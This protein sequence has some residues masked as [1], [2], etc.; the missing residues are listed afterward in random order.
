GTRFGNSSRCTRPSTR[1]WHIEWSP[2]FCDART[3]DG[4]RLVGRVCDR[5]GAW[6]LEM[7]LD[8]M[9]SSGGGGLDLGWSSVDL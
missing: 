5:V 4:T 6:V 8:I 3:R 2:V 7:V 9:W 1:P